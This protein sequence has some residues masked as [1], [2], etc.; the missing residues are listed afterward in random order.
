MNV[1]IISIG[2]MS[3]NPLW[4]ERAGARTGH[5]TTTLV[6]SGDRRILVDPGLPAP[7]L[8]ARLAERANLSPADVTDVFLTSFHPETRRALGAFEKARW[9]VSSTERETVG[10][11]LAQQLRRLAEQT[12]EA[13]TEAR[14]LVQ[15]LEGEVALLQRCEPAEDSIAPNVDLFPLP[16]LTPGLCGLLIEGERFTT[17][18]CGDAI[19]TEQ[20][21]LEG[22]VLPGA[23]DLDQ[24]RDSFQDAVE[25]ADMLVL[26]R[27]NI[28]VNP[29]KRPF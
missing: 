6:E 4:N 15:T 23:A 13:D 18:V 9:L 27:D 19:P 21:L 26:G 1:R 8:L 5:T 28:V 3:A 29:T 16:G 24:A 14:S 11:T 20:H 2:A 25:V 10:V 12:S 17:L 22:K 7:A